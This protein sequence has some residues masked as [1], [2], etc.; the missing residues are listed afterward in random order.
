M[1]IQ[2][3]DYT[4]VIIPSLMLHCKQGLAFAIPLEKEKIAMEIRYLYLMII[5]ILL[6]IVGFFYGYFIHFV[7][8]AYK[9]FA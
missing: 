4:L 5:V 6:A 1:L 2:Y 7:E 8:V 9:L 3:D